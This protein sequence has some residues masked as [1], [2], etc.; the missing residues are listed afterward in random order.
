MIVA[1][2]YCVTAYYI[3]LK[4]YVKIVFNIYSFGIILK[5]SHLSNTF[6]IKIY[7]TDDIFS[8]FKAMKWDFSFDVGGLSLQ[9]KIK[10]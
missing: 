1:L 8:E 7:K 2:I 10:T 4:V 3:N 5:N 9:L 6:F